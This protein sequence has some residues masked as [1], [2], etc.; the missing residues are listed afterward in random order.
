MNQ[1]ERIVAPTISL[2]ISKVKE[3]LGENA[4][5][6][7]TEKFEDQCAIIAKAGP[8]KKSEK[9]ASVIKLQEVQNEK[10]QMDPL[11]FIQNVCDICE[12]HQ[13]GEEFCQRWLKLLSNDL[14]LKNINLKD[15]LS[16]FI[17]FS[18]LDWLCEL[19]NKRKIVFVGPHGSGKLLQ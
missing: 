14:T 5:I 6:L 18:N 13:L 9:R 2:A 7:A 4:I 11:A 1:Q 12:Q 8:Q 19:V 15:S 10:A 3:K 16:R 17:Q